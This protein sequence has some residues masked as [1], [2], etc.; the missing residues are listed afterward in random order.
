MPELIIQPTVI[1]YGM[2]RG[3]YDALADELRDGGWVV[4]L[5]DPSERTEYRSLA[6]EVAQAGADLLVFVDA[7]FA[8]GQAL[9][10]LI[11]LLRRRLGRAGSKRK[12]T[13][14]IYGPR[15]EELSR[16]ELSQD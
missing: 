5:V 14:I 16:V 4:R 13:V 1:E 15:G 2:N 3:I 8:E 6:H 7:H 11:G 9:A 10:T 12:R